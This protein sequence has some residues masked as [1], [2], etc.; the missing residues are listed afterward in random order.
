MY[1]GAVPVRTISKRGVE[2]TIRLFPLTLHA[3]ADQ[4]VRGFQ[5]ASYREAR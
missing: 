3:L 2:G 4:G 1:V 5:D